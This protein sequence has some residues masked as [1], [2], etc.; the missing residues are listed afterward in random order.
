MW[1]LMVPFHFQA[2][3]SPK[4]ALSHVFLAGCPPYNHHLF[5]V[6]YLAGR[7]NGPEEEKVRVKMS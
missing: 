2:L 4:V 6:R 5:V 3:E 1:K 7:N